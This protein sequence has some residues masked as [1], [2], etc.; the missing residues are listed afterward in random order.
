MVSA[1]TPAT[2]QLRRAGIGFEIHHYEVDERRDESY[3]E[4]V[5]ASLGVDPHRV[6]KTLVAMVDGSPVVAIVP[7]VSVMSLKKLAKAAGGKKAKMADPHDAERLTGYVV[8]GISPFG[9]RRR[10]P[11][12]CDRSAADLETMFVS[13]GR[14][15]IQLEMSPDDLISVTGATLVDLVA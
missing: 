10:L 7:V 9:Q 15:G 6:F 5:A 2:E 12:F 8:G 4:A 13:G 1:A 14:R 3:G 11:F